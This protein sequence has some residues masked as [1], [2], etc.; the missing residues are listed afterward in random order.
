MAKR[1]NI[2]IGR[3]LSIKAD[4]IVV[5]DEESSDVCGIAHTEADGSIIKC[6]YIDEISAE[7]TSKNSWNSNVHETRYQSF[8]FEHTRKIRLPSEDYE[9]L[10]TGF[11]GIIEGT[12]DDYAGSPKIQ[13]QIIIS[14]FTPIVSFD[15][16]K[17]TD[18]YFSYYEC[19]NIEN[20][21][22]LNSRL[23]EILGENHEI[24][25]YALNIV[26]KK[27]TVR[28]NRRKGLYIP[29]DLNSPSYGGVE[30]G[31]TRHSCRNMAIYTFPNDVFIS[32]VISDPN[33]V[34]RRDKEHRYGDSSYPTKEYIILYVV[35][36]DDVCGAISNLSNP[37]YLYF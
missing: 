31:A 28:N 5:L 8:V 34:T 29:T 33:S 15:P 36:R 12:V 6:K 32:N 22:E 37:I 23:I 26:R 7:R 20:L 3:N 18:D 17:L 30:K 24:D 4:N 2:E 9:E 16:S 25:R 14:E 35:I 19:F 1:N 21:D 11:G 10:G 13:R 27:S